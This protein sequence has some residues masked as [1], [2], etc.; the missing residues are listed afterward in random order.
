LNLGNI[1][2]L[3]QLFPTN[4]HFEGAFSATEKSHESKLR[5]LVALFRSLSYF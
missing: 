4:R 2:D 3:M 5:F 1:N